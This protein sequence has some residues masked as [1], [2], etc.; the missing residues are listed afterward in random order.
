MNIR[1]LFKFLNK[2]LPSPSFCDAYCVPKKLRP[3]DAFTTWYLTWLWA[4][5]GKLAL[6]LHSTKQASIN[7]LS[8][9]TT[10]LLDAVIEIYW[11]KDW[12]DL[13]V[14]K[15]KICTRTQFDIFMHWMRHKLAF[16]G[17]CSIVYGNSKSG[18]SIERF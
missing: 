9:F 17:T 11:N 6:L 16:F 5:A 4:K 13:T 1:T 18:L 14:L 8:P 7:H 12:F 15:T 10:C 2:N 3:L